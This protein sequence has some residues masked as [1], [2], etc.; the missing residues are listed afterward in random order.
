MKKKNKSEESALFG[1][2]HNVIRD[3]FRENER[4]RYAVFGGEK[5]R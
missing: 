3:W 2:S 1:Y 5:L 4:G